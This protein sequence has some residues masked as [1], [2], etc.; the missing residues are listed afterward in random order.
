MQ[1]PKTHPRE[2]P[3]AFTLIE[4]LVVIAIIAILVALL[5][6]AVQQA[7]EAAR[8][9]ACKNNLKQIGLA[10]HNYHDTHNVF[11]YSTAHASSNAGT[12]SGTNV[13]NH[14]GWVLLLPYIEQGALYDQYNFSW[15][16]GIRNASGGTVAGGTDP[17]INTNLNLSRNRVE[18][19]L[20]PSDNGGKVYTG[21]DGTYGCGVANAYRSNYGFSVNSGNGGT[22]WGS[23]GISSRA[24]FGLNAFC[25][26]KDIVD[27][28]SNT[29][30]V[31]E[32][33]LEVDDG[34]TQSWSCSSHVGQGINLAASRGINNFLC[35][36][37]RTP[38]NAQYQYGR[39][40]EWG[41][42]GSLH[43]GGIQILLADGAVRF[44]SENVNATTRTYLQR[45]SDGQVLGEF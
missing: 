26:M 30:A 37:W 24:M 6:P 38:P 23:Y 21:A 8:R 16:T 29:V 18:V 15:A 32:T 34:R 25:Q 4:L 17:A 13:L 35:C 33:T 31:V 43:Q 20:C 5:L 41:E 40:G 2:T 12:P 14:S 9:S 42:P 1:R 3:R 7:R 22:F 19:Y 36:S 11:P 27:G 44:L 10:L 45:I 28:T 39:N